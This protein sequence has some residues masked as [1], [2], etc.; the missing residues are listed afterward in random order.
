MNHLEIQKHANRNGWLAALSLLLCLVIT[1]PI[2][3]QQ[4]GLYGGPRQQSRQDNQMPPAIQNVGIDQK[5]NEQVPLDLAFRDEE[6]REVR[7]GEYFGR[8]PVIL[9][10]VYYEC[11]MLC[12]QV[13]NGLTS[14]LK[15]L[16]FSTGQE[17][18]VL[19]VSFDPREGPELAARKKEAYVGRY[20]RPGEGG[21][22]HFLTGAPD[23]IQRLT[24]AAGFRYGF[25]EKTNQFVHASGIMVLTP[26]GRLARYFY[27]IDYAPRDLRLGLI[28]AS[29]NRIGSPVDQLLLYCY[30][31][32]PASG[33]YGVVL[34]NVL[35]LSALVFLLALGGLFLVLRWWKP[36]AAR[37]AKPVNVETRSVV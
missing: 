11:P 9:A 13:L 6:G 8:R 30:H 2:C 26:Q 23:S 34:L 19:A 3:A 21:G 10:L 16:S 12:N 5:L 27:G 33:K 22:W 15:A 29:E 25:D 36:K 35:K 37:A 4:G 20:G 24:E 17:Y 1:Q 32:D 28:E 18:E 14:S 7:L 31:Y